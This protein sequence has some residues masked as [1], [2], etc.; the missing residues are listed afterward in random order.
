[1]SCTNGEDVLVHNSKLASTRCLLKED[2]VK[3]TTQ[4][5]NTL[6]NLALA[7]GAKNWNAIASCMNEKFPSSVKTSKQCRE[8]WHYC[9][10]MKIDH[11]PWTKQ[12]EAKL[13][14]AHMDY[15]NRWCDIASHLKGRH[16]NMVKN[17]F[18]S[19]LRK[20]KNKIRNDVYTSQDQLEVIEMHYMT[21]VMINYIKNPAPM[22]D[23]G[24]KR[25]RDFMH[26]LVNDI[27]ITMLEDFNNI[28]LT[29]HP[30][31]E[32]LK[33]S[34]QRVIENDEIQAKTKT[35]PVSASGLLRVT[36][37]AHTV[38]L[39]STMNLQRILE[40]CWG[41]KN[42]EF[43]LPRPSSFMGGTSFSQDEKNLISKE[44]LPQRLPDISFL[45]KA[46]L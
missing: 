1:M 16:N 28:F 11:K 9:L 40:L 21:F 35:S 8:R 42:V 36:S 25:G 45:Y 7:Y 29:Y 26:T 38:S 37:D 18:Y 46:I 33:A 5:D 30:L 22:E 20:V 19:I 17:R 13:L 43:V 10:D 23:S 14:L 41:R 3:W 6:S 15:G 12:E 44:L 31:K 32:P 27:T 2:R 4:Q 34:L 24:R 39:D